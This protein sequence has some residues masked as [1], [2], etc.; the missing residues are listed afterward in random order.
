MYID[1]FCK[2]TIDPKVSLVF[3]HVVAM[4]APR[5]VRV[6]CLTDGACRG[7]EFTVAKQPLSMLEFGLAQLALTGPPMHR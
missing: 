7:G 3:S 2:N 1:V 5:G 6:R 4:A